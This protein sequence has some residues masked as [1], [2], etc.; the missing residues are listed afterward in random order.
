M[1]QG[2]TMDIN[3]YLSTLFTPLGSTPYGLDGVESYGRNVAG[4]AAE[5]S[6]FAGRAGIDQTRAYE[7]EYRPYDRQFMN[8]VDSIGSNGYRGQ[9]RSMA[10][11]DVQLQTDAQRQQMERQGA[12]AGVNYGD[13]RFAFMRGQMA[14]QT[15]LNKV[16][17]AMGSDRNSRDEWSKGLGAINAMGLKVGEMGMRN[18]ELSGNLGKV[19]MAGMDLG[20]AARDRNTNA[21]ASMTSA[22]AAGAGAAA[23]MHNAELNYQLGLGRLALDRYGLETG[24]AL[25]IRGLDDAAS[26]NSFGNTFLSSAGGAATNWLINGGAGKLASG[27]GNLFGNGSAYTNTVDDNNDFNGVTG[28]NAMDTWA[29]YGSGAD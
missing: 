9:Q 7:E 13:P 16:M 23:S 17:A 2:N 5:G 20:P 29:T 25:K 10:M 27:I 26:A 8:Y 21:Q 15:A 24:N 4:A 6:L 22:G 12:A 28:S 1:K 18:M 14:Q 3:Q 11:N 19:G